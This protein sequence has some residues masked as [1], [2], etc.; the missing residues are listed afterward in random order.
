MLCAQAA[1]PL[2][3]FPCLGDLE[4]CYG[5][6]KGAWDF[7]Q[8]H[9]YFPW[10][11]SSGQDLHLLLASDSS[12]CLDHGTICLTGKAMQDE[13]PKAPRMLSASGTTASISPS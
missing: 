5:L 13:L 3:V 7:C 8:S 6:L 9:L 2:L 11:G 4:R 10:V 12:L 1:G